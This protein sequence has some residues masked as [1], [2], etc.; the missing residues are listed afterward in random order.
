[1][2]TNKIHYKDV[3]KKNCH[4]QVT[5]SITTRFWEGQA[6]AHSRGQ[7]VLNNFLRIH[8]TS[9]LELHKQLH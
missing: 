6:H 5:D 1:M 9:K 2:I 3:T 8:I 7:Q 4:I